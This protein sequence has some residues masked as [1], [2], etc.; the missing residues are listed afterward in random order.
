MIISEKRGCKSGATADTY[1]VTATWWNYS[2]RFLRDYDRI[3][4]SDIWLITCN[5]L[6]VIFARYYMLWWKGLRLKHK[7]KK[8]YSFK[9]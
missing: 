9:Y 3:A 5:N 6:G 8:N 2:E 1:H 4:S 7:L